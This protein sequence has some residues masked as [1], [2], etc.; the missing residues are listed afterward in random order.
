MEELDVLVGDW[1]MQGL[2]FYAGNVT[3][4]CA[5]TGDGS[6]TAI[7]VPKFKC[8]LLS[9]D[10]DG[11]NIGRDGKSNCELAAQVRPPA[12]GLNRAPMHLYQ[13]TRQCQSDTKPPC[14][15]SLGV[16]AA[17]ANAGL[18]RLSPTDTGGG[19]RYTAF[20]LSGSWAF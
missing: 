12:V 16:S 15:S 3:Y 2:P 8:P 4:H 1:T 11:R 14:V 13:A 10:L 19:Y 9:V 7:E 20:S 18:Q 5:I 6:K 17:Y